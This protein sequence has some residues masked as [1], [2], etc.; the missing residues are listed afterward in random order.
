MA[1]E[2]QSRLTTSVG[3]APGLT[4]PRIQ[5]DRQMSTDSATWENPFRD[6]GDLS[7]DADY[8]VSALKQG[9]LSVV[10]MSPSTSPIPPSIT[11]D[12]TDGGTD[13]SPKRLDPV[14]EANGPSNGPSNGVNSSN[15]KPAVVEVQHGVVVNAKQMGVEHIVIPEEKKKKCSC[16]VI[17]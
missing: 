7:K 13:I 1:D 2:D 4:N 9:K 16:C 8:I 15:D 3:N 17:Q 12:G 14:K 11:P 5:V 6:G 10:S